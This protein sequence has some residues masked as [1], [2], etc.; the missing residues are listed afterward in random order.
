ML[1]YSLEVPRQGASNEYP[2]HVFMEKKENILWI[3]HLSGA[4]EIYV[5]WSFSW[6]LDSIWQSSVNNQ[7]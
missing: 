1:W 7:N 2:Q 6:H 3:P 4:M 5:F